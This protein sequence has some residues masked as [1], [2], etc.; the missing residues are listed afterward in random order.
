MEQG[1]K[2]WMTAEDLSVADRFIEQN[3]DINSIDLIL[4]DMNGME[5]GKRIPVCMLHKVIKNGVCMPASVFALDITGETVEETGLGFELGDGD[6]LCRI[7]PGT[8]NVTPW[9]EGV[10]QAVITMLN[11]D[12][13]Q[14]F[15]ADP[16]NVLHRQIGEMTDRHFYPC[17]A[18]EF[19]FYLQDNKLDKNGC[20]QPPIM[21]VSGKR[22]TQTQVYSLEE[23]DEFRSFIDEVISVCEIQDIPASNIIA[24]YAPG[25]FEVNL[26]HSKDVLLACDQ[27]MLMKR[28]IRAIAKKHGFEANFMAKPY[29]EHAGNGC[30][31]HI[32]M[33]D[34]M[35]VNVFCN[36]PKVFENAIGGILKC[37]PDTM[38]VL[39]P[40][41][42]SFRRF[43]P[44][45]FVSLWPNWGWDNRTVAVRIPSGNLE[46]TRI[47]HRLPGADCNPFLVI[48]TIMA[49]MLEGIDKKIEPPEAIEGNAYDKE[50]EN[51]LP[52][53]WPQ[54]LERFHSSEVLSER[55]TPRFCRVY[56][57]S[58][59]SEQIHFFSKVSPLEYEWYM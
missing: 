23:L 57:E 47:E 24:E 45:M 7:V 31:I 46:D 37:M 4:F 19:E 14:G 48:G 51:F 22:M 52:L 26:K 38:A 43:Q 56:H 15:F 13:T 28:V 59:H 11:R 30:H 44:N 54:A 2:K 39:A 50:G 5:R 1:R 34:A 10:A 8:L 49:T 33:M 12:E 9:K 6:R 20:P 58:K 17:V 41:A 21:P 55:L 35:G 25:Q 3:P 16:R 53:S 32:S 40:N 18:V 29:T 36:Q 27:A 42:N